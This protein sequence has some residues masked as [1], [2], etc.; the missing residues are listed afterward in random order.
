MYEREKSLKFF[1][2]RTNKTIFDLNSY[3][4]KSYYLDMFVIFWEAY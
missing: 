1:N 4:D 3:N 2:K